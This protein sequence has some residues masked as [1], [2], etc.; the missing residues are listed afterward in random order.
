MPGAAERVCREHAGERAVRRAPAVERLGL[1]DR[2]A[3]ERVPEP[4]AQ[5][6]EH[7][8]AR[9][10]PSNTPTITDVPDSCEVAATISGRVSS[11]DTAATNSAS[12]AIFGSC[13]AGPANERSSRVVTVAERTDDVVAHGLL[14]HSGATSGTGWGVPGHVAV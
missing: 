1:Q 11:P 12:R 9:L 8:E 4:D 14:G 10:A 6:V 3:D 5:V 2:G 7:D 13:R